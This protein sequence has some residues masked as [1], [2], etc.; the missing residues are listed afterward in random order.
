MDM[1]GEGQRQGSTSGLSDSK[2]MLCCG[3]LVLR[4]TPF[5]ESLGTMHSWLTG[6]SPAGRAI[7]TSWF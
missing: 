4:L 2:L 7:Q 3:L 1:V 5:P 6:L